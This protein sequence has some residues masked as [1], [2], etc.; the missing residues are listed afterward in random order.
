MENKF[1]T[2]ELEN[3]P[4][5]DLALKRI[6]AWYQQEIIDRPPIRFS[7]HNAEY[8]KSSHLKKT[9]PSLKERWFDAEYQVDFF[10]DSIKGRKFY[11]ETFPV[12]WPNL[13]PEVYSAFHG[14]ELEYME[15][16]S[17][18]IPIIKSWEDSRL[19]NFDMN[20]IY[21]RKIE[22][23]T[24]IA[25]E[26]CEGK[27]M[28]GYTDLHP[29]MDCVAA[30]RDPQQ[31]CM[32]ILL[33]PDNVKEVIR[34]ANQHFQKIF[35]YFDD[36]LK[37]HKQLSVTWM[38]IPSY[39]KMH[40]P[41]CD[42]SAMLSTDQYLEFIHPITV[43]EVKKMTHNI[44]HLDGKGVAKNIDHILDIKEI[45]AIQWVQGMGKDMPIMQWIPLIKK[46]QAAKKSLV[47]DIQLSELE[48]FIASMDP[49]GIMLCITADETITPDIIKRIEKW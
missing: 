47:L 42:F 30:W 13:G 16:T 17:Y 34:L 12:F 10:I 45:N 9:W 21:F 19:I 27:F 8:V 39:G 37:S 43:E 32:D 24:Q 4:D 33:S 35:D 38:G 41:S 14:C 46:I 7:S 5:F 28:V 48:D 20:N 26:K 23:M 11:A 29:G 22:E 1:W 31:L 44:Y 3:K 15:V 2:L 6:Y 18:S 25:L 36:L 40:I 49:H